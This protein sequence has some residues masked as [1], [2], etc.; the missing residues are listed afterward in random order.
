[1]KPIAIK[2]NHLYKKAYLGG[3]KAGG[4]FTSIYVLKDKKAYFLKK[5]NPSKEYVNRLGLAVTK[6]VGCAVE[7]NRAKRVVRAAYSALCAE[8]PLRKGFL[9]VI[10]I[11]DAAVLA[12]ST[13]VLAEMRKQMARLQM[14]ANE[15]MNTVP[16]EETE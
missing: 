12:K 3:K 11:R 1:M 9:I 7:R 8:E 10:S 13:E 2:E 5:S 14:F 4:R 6:K 15:E 16:R